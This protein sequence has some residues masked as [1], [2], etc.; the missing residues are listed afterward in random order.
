M[1]RLSGT[2]G[3]RG[4]VCGI[5][6]ARVNDSGVSGDPA[7]GL[8]L[9]SLVYLQAQLTCRPVSSSWQPFLMSVTRGKQSSRRLSNWSTV[10]AGWRKRWEV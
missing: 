9:A 2:Q 5:T 1:A 10:I 7:G 8:Q 4:A 6:F 3:R